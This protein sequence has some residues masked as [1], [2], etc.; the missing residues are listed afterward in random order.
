VDGAPLLRLFPEATCSICKEGQKVVRALRKSKTQ[1]K[2]KNQSRS[3]ATILK[4][5]VEKWPG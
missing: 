2:N 4:G 3:A 1:L 5:M